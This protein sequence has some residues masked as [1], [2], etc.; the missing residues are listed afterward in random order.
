MTTL[1]KPCPFCGSTD[2]SAIKE[3]LAKPAPEPVG[4]ITKYRN[5]HVEAEFISLSSLQQG[6]LYL[7]PPPP[8][9]PEGWQLVPKEPTPEMLNA[10]EGDCDT[11]DDYYKAMLAAAPS[12]P[13]SQGEG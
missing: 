10:A 4:W 2:I 7:A 11:F 12:L 1:L 13:P 3:E 6:P 8:K 9:V 5:S